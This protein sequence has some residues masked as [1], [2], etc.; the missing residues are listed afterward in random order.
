[1]FTNTYRYL[2]ILAAAFCFLLLFPSIK[3]E[4]EQIQQTSTEDKLQ[5]STL[6]TRLS[7][8]LQKQQDASRQSNEDRIKQLL[9]EFFRI[10]PYRRASSFHAMRGKRFIQAN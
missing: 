8:I 3:C 5:T 7:F 1:M 4:D 10:Y 2:L 9:E 6:H